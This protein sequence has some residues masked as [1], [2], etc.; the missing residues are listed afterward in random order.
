MATGSGKTFTAIGCIKKINSKT[1]NVLVIIAVPY[2]N[3][4]DQWAKELKK[5]SIEPKKT[6]SNK[7]GIHLTWR[8]ILYE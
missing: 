3:L 7:M 8:N 2:A 4:I 5:W 1:K 6:H